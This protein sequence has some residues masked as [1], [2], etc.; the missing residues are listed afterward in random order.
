MKKF[1][2]VCE[3]GNVRSVAL[4]FVL[5]EFHNRDAIA[6]GWRFAEND[7]LEILCKWADAIVVMQPHF[8]DKLPEAYREKAL[9][10]DVGPD[11]FGSPFHPDL[12]EFLKNVTEDWKIRGWFE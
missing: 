10:V 12:Y 8:K 1:L 3:G 6:C 2:C 11:R 9:V 7:T 4:A 5:K